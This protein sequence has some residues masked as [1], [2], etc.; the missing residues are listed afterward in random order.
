MNT[1][2]SR[3]EP[4]IGLINEVIDEFNRRFQVG[5]ILL[6]Q[7]EIN[8]QFPDIPAGTKAFIRDGKIY[9]NGSLATSEDVIHEYTHLFLGALKA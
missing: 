7:D 4:I 8:Q 6:T 9:I 3:P 1:T 5:A 2:Y